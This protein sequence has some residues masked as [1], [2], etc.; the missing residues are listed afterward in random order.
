[1][2]SDACDKGGVEIF[3]WKLPLDATLKAGT[4]FWI[5]N[6]ES[7]R[8]DKTRQF[9]GRPWRARHAARGLCAPIKEAV[10]PGWFFVAGNCRRNSDIALPG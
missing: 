6:E 2:T 8:E 10:S 3:Q 5:N 1:M 4:V 9:Y 7:S